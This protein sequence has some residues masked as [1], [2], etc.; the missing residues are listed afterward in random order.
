MTTNVGT[1]DRI[2]RAALGLVLLYFAFFSGLHLFAEP[3]IKYGTAV[4]G[5]VMLATSTIKMCPLYAIFG[6]KTCREC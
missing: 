4:V 1:L 3:L 6:I 2:L 5:I